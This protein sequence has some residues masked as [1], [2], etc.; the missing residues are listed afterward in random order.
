MPLNADKEQPSL[1]KMSSNQTLHPEGTPYLYDRTSDIVLVQN[2]LNHAQPAL[3]MTKAL[4]GN[5]RKALLVRRKVQKLEQ[6]ME[7]RKTWLQQELEDL[8]AYI[9]EH[10][11][12]LSDPGN[13]PNADFGELQEDLAGMVEQRQGYLDDINSL[14]RFII[15]T[16]QRQARYQ[17]LVDDTLEEVFVRNKLLPGADERCDSERS[18][19]S[20]FGE[21]TEATRVTSQSPK[22]QSILVGRESQKSLRF[23]YPPEASIQ[24]HDA[25]M[26]R[27]VHQ[28][29]ASQTKARMIEQLFKK[30]RYDVE[31]EV[32]APSTTSTEHDLQTLVRGQQLTRQLID[33]H[34]ELDAAK[35]E[36]KQHGGLLPGEDQRSRF[37]D[38]PDDGYSVAQETLWIRAVDR[39]DIEA[40]MDKTEP[41]S[42]SFSQVTS[43][44]GTLDFLE[45]VGLGESLTVQEELWKNPDRQRIDDWMCRMEAM[46]KEL[47]ATRAP[48]QQDEARRSNEK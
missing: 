27:L 37:I 41:S 36:W 20:D 7:R 19:T 46:R 34:A 44:R 30:H 2:E 22:E 48:P 31:T 35:L 16:A 26:S 15:S 8:N 21:Q 43:D 33:A 39:Q 47:N 14:D 32:P 25:M 28:M 42:R 4:S 3:L 6:E 13:Y 5:I 1:W 38:D 29:T 23:I 9:E 40:W 18:S 24:E 45:D 17:R 10:E 11:M 12:V